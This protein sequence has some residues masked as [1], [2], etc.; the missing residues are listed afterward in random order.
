MWR[1]PSPDASTVSSSFCQS[2]KERS[3]SFLWA[4][5]GNGKYHFYSH[6]ISQH[7]VVGSDLTAKEAGKC[8]VACAHEE[9]E[10]SFGMHMAVSV[11]VMGHA[12]TWVFFTVD[13]WSLPARVSDLVCSIPQ[14]R[15]HPWER[16]HSH[17][18]H[19]L[20]CPPSHSKSHTFSQ[21][22]LRN[23]QITEK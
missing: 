10:A 22:D 5:H 4:R 19:W 20:Y 17:K 23:S 3:H 2:I 18:F 11:T 7:S 9:H 14:H 6:P 13:H 8:S 1:H 15:K 21:E 16:G 12:T